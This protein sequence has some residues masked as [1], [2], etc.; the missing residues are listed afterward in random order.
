[1]TILQDTRVCEEWIAPEIFA[2]DDDSWLYQGLD[3][4]DDDLER[5]DEADVGL[6]EPSNSDMFDPEDLADGMKAFV[7]KLASHEGAEIPTGR[8]RNK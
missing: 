6:Q 3:K 4:M 1:M 7:Q 5:W 8:E 2:E